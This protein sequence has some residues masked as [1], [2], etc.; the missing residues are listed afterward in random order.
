MSIKLPT[1]T[2][3]NDNNQNN[4]GANNDPKAKYE[5]H[6]ETYNDYW[7]AVGMVRYLGKACRT[8]GV[9]KVKDEGSSPWAD[10]YV[11]FRAIK[12]D[13][14]DRVNGDGEEDALPG[15]LP[16]F[17]N[18][19]ETPE[20][21][22]IEVTK[23]NAADYGLDPETFNDDEDPIYVMADYEAPEEVYYAESGEEATEDDV[24]EALTTVDGIGEG[25]A[26]KALE[27]LKDAGLTVV[28][29]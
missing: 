25:R 6:E 13:L 22:H 1:Q 7:Q 24:T 14:K 10:H 16:D 3:S 15:S 5:G 9:A 26:E 17:R 21:D 2:A 8:L 23:E 28:Y 20:W 11:H 19:F 18:V 12:D 29:E 27:A 4:S